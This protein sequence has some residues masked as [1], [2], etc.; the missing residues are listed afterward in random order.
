MVFEI[1][2]L[3]R[4]FSEYQVTVA[5]LVESLAGELNSMLVIFFS[6]KFP[7]KM[8]MEK[9]NRLTATQIIPCSL[10]NGR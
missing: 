6:L 3:N 4:Q 2:K 10:A 1:L 5:Q 7:L 9:N 8:K